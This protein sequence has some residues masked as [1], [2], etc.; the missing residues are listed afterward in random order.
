MQDFADTRNSLC[1]Q[2]DN[3]VAFPQ[4][5][6]GMCKLLDHFVLDI[7][8]LDHKELDNRDLQAHPPLLVFLKIFK[9]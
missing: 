3:W 8:N 4:K 2:D 6:E 1:I 7:A 5:L 9:F